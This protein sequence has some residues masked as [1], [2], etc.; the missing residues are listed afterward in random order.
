P[1]AAAPEP[2]ASVSIALD[3]QGQT[4]WG[5]QAIDP[6]SLPQRL[7]EA[8]QRDP[9][10]E[11]QLR[12]DTAVPYGRVVQIIGLAQTAGLSRIGFVADPS[13]PAPAPAPAR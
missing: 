12:A 1:A 10:T 3:A 13:T 5:D 9:G 11:L 4:F 2:A 6:A 8:A 7:Q